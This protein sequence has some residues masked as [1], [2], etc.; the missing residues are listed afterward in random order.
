MFHFIMLNYSMIIE[1][2]VLTIKK[3]YGLVEIWPN[4]KS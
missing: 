2:L 4:D 1:E 3:L